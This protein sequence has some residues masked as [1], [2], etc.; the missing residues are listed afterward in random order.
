MYEDDS[1]VTLPGKES[2]VLNFAIKIES[3]VKESTWFWT[4]TAEIL[5]VYRVLQPRIING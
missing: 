1:W 3:V 2:C 5:N 4:N